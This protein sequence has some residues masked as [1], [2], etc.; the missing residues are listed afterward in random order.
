[1]RVKAATCKPKGENRDKNETVNSP[2]HSDIIGVLSF[3][4][5]ALMKKQ[6]SSFVLSL[7]SIVHAEICF[8]DQRN[9]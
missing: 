7:P 2:G 6:K 5:Q 8:V 3:L 1:M 9:V 4:S